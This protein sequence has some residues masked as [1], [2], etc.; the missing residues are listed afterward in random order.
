M[1]L[2]LV[3]RHFLRPL[4]RPQMCRGPSFARAGVQT[5]QGD[6]QTSET[7]A[8]LQDLDET[9]PTLV[10]TS[11]KLVEATINKEPQLGRDNANVIETCPML[12]E[13]RPKLAQTGGKMDRTRRKM[14]ETRRDLDEISTRWVKAKVKPVGSSQNE[15]DAIRPHTIQCTSNLEEDSPSLVKRSPH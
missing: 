2:S 3:S 12:V 6:Q 4:R 10:E 14:V 9:S 8:G 1:R 11:P 15:K 7:K 13:A 5:R